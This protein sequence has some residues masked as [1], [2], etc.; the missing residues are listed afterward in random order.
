MKQVGANSIRRICPGTRPLTTTLLLDPKLDFQIPAPR[1]RKVV[2][3]VCSNDSI[4]SLSPAVKA[5]E[6]RTAV[7]AAVAAEVSAAVAVAAAA[8]MVA[9]VVRAMAVTVVGVVVQPS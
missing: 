6:R 2:L 5:V 3:A 7:V 4:E 8:A 1:T 9:K